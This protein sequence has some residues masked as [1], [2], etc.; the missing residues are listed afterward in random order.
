MPSR[1]ATTPA[2][3]PSGPA[4]TSNRYAAKRCSCARA[5]SAAMILVAVMAT[6]DVST[7][8]EYIGARSVSQRLFADRR[9]DGLI[10]LGVPPLVRITHKMA[11]SLTRR[12]T[13]Y[14]VCFRSE[15]ASRSNV[16]RT[17]GEAQARRISQRIPLLSKTN[18]R[19]ADDCNFGGG[20]NIDETLQQRVII[21]A[22]LSQLLVRLWR[23]TGGGSD[24]RSDRRP[25]RYDTGP[26]VGESEA[27]C[28]GT[29]GS[30]Q[31]ETWIIGLE[32]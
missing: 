8:V 4:S 23:Q 25:F 20:L 18:P 10:Y 14:A 28:L 26:M 15:A 5:A 7:N 21:G 22:K 29:A 24:M 16:G 27:L 13:S 9:N 31:T 32:R 19:T 12:V 17:M 2:D 30:R 3:S 11:T 1:S 6:F